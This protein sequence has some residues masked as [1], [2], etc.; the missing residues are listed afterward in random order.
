MLLHGKPLVHG[1]VKEILYHSVSRHLLPYTVLS[2]MVR[3]DLVVLRM[4]IILLPLTAGESFRYK[5]ILSLE[6]LLRLKDLEVLGS[7]L[8]LLNLLQLIQMRDRC[9]SHSLVKSVRRTQKITMVLV[10]L[11]TS[12][13]QKKKKYLLGM[14]LVNLV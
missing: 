8:V 1:L 10:H 9:C 7:S 14:D 5:E 13:T 4:L 12:L 2:L 3:Y 11:I 6:L